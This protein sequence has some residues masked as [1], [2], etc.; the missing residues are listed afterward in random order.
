VSYFNKHMKSHN[1]ADRKSL[2]VSEKIIVDNQGILIGYQK[3]KVVQ[4]DSKSE[5]VGEFVDCN[6]TM[7]SEVKEELLDEDEFD[8]TLPYSFST[9]FCVEDENITISD[10]SKETE[11]IDRGQTVKEEVINKRMINS[12]H[13]IFKSNSL[14]N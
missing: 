12:E 9:D 10:K 3:L 13:C 5:I 4:E 7:K 8:E 1:V 14:M 2:V 6:E 11:L